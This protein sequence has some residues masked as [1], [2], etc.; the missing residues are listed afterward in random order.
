MRF[1]CRFYLFW[2]LAPQ[3]SFFSSNSFQTLI[4]PMNRGLMHLQL[5][6]LQISFS[7]ELT[8]ATCTNKIKQ[9]FRLKTCICFR[10]LKRLLI[11]TTLVSQR[12]ETTWQYYQMGAVLH[13][14][15]NPI[16]IVI[17]SQIHGNI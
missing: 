1:F 8:G 14:V 11:Y 2:L 13:T 9:S 12:A 4:C 10:S 17:Q 6:L 7:T 3:S 16:G 5:T 15:D